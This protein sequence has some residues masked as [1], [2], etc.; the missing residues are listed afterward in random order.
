M[1]LKKSKLYLGGRT[2]KENGS[3]YSLLKKD[4]GCQA[5]HLPGEPGSRG[6]SGRPYLAIPMGRACPGALLNR[7]PET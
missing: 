7:Q 4:M 1:N 5:V 2:L 3:E 6:G